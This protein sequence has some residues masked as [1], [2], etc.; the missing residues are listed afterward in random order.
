MERIYRFLVLPVSKN[1]HFSPMTLFPKTIIYRKEKKLVAT[2][3]A[4]SFTVGTGFPC[5]NVLVFLGLP[6][7]LRFGTT[8]TC[9]E[10]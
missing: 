6:M 1:A 7:R 9:G 8:V 5:N 4:T 10:A 2:V 3:F